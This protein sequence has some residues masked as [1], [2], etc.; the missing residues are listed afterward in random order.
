MSS[1]FTFTAMAVLMLAMAPVLAGG[2][3]SDEGPEVLLEEGEELFTPEDASSLDTELP[4][5]AETTL[6]ALE[7]TSPSL[8]PASDSHPAHF[9]A[10]PSRPDVAPVAGPSVR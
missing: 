10:R 9:V 1:K 3:P 6:A 8:P 2:M 7:F 5:Y 4:V